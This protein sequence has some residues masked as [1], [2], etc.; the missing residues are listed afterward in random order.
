MT[1]QDAEFVDLFERVVAG[2]R[3]AALEFHALYANY[4]LH[5]VRKKLHK[6]LRSKFDSLDFVQDVWASFFED[7]PNK[8]AFDGPDALVAFLTTVAHNK[9]VQ[10]MR[11]RFE[12]QKYDVHR[13]ISL[14]VFP[15][16]GDAF[17]ALQATPSEI[18]M[19][20]EEWIQFLEKQPL[21]HRR[22]F[23]L[24]REGKSSVIIAEE[25]GISKRTV[26]RVLRN[27]VERGP[28]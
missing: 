17:A 26:N 27:L 11:T 23:L 22:I 16:G 25:L 13:E 24:L 9:V 18:F 10:A 19:S 4:I 20:E 12:T 28:P 2:N 21:V 5:A 1:N 15:K 7:L 6:R 8:L 3:E 14:E